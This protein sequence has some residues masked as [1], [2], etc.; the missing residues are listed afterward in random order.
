MQNPSILNLV[1]FFFGRTLS[2]NQKKYNFFDCKIPNTYSYSTT[3]ESQQRKPHLNIGTIGIESALTY[4][5]FLLT[6][7]A[8]F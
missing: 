7:A 6:I 4:F 1:R 3:A 2:K 5:F 8:Y